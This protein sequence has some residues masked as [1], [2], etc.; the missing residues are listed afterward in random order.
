MTELTPRF[1]KNKARLGPFLLLLILLGLESCRPVPD[2]L[3]NSMLRTE[4]APTNGLQIQFLGNTN[5]LI[6]DGETQILTDGFF[7]RPSAL[8]IVLGKVKP[9]EKR[10]KECLEKAGITQLDV[11]I[12]VH[13]HYDHAMD[14]PLVAQ[15]TGATLIGS[16]STLM[17]GEGAGLNP[18][19]MKLAPLDSIVVIGKFKLRF[20]ASRHW[21]YPSEKQRKRLLDQGIEAPLVMP[22][23]IYDFK[24]GISYTLLIEHDSTSIAIH[25]SAGYV[26]NALDDFDVDIAFL[27]I[28]GLEAMD[29]TY[30]NAYQ[31]HTIEAL[32]PEVIVPIHWDDFTV[33]LR[34][35]LKTTSRF[36]NFLLG[37][38]LE[39]AIDI[40]Q[41]NNPDR[42]MIFLH[43]WDRYSVKNLIEAQVQESKLD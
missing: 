40:V 20:I 11:V 41:K 2:Q 8:R 34:E 26:E 28:A 37:A 29:E 43:L 32:K 27:S 38:D 3:R 31:K 23:S 14:A 33:P 21:H 16:S 25:G 5:I 35:E 39:E 15:M 24:E 9:K 10:I 19:Q 1:T 36:A 42:K 4:A 30:N 12:P 22:A 17:I 6:D 18:E 7:S 13:S